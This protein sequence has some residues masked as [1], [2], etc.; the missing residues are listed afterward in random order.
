MKS[1]KTKLAAAAV[2]GLAAFLT[3]NLIDTSGIVWADVVQRL[4]AIKT[5]TYTITEAIHGMPGTPEGY[6]THKTQDVTLS[7]EQNAV[8]IDSS[9]QVPGGTRKMQTYI[10]FDKSA[11]YTVIPAQKKYFKVTISDEQ[12]QKMSEENG[13]PATILKAMLEHDYT[14]L[15]RQ[16]IDGVWA[17][18]IEVSDPKLGTKMGASISGGIYDETT[19]Q[20]WVDEKTELP[21]RINATGSSKDGKA[22][23][24]VVYDHFQWDIDID[25]AQLTPE[26]PDDYEL[27]AQGTWETGNEGEEI[28]EVLRLFVEFADGQ[29]PASLKTMTVAKAITPALQKKFPRGSAK[30]S[31]ELIARLMKVDMIGTMYTTLEKDGKE[32]AYYGDRVSAESPEAVLFRWKTDENTYRV[33]FG[34]LSTKDV[35]PAELAELEAALPEPQQD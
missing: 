13:D 25:P 6:V 32:P 9:L 22:S 27:M 11:L 23:M 33:V 20:L 3:L 30:P 4:E 19:V 31:K 34:D 18:G 24:D 28:I 12:M 26:I 14:E 8:R 21:M 35:T 5:G 16:R 17:R 2:I 15:G 1:R 29:Y 10:L 7:Y